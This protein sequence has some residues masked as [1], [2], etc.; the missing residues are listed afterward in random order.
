MIEEILKAGGNRRQH[1]KLP[2]GFWIRKR[3]AGA[4]PVAQWFSSHVLLLG[5]PVQSP[6][7]GMAPL[8]TPYCGRCPTHKVE[9]DGYGC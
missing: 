3:T 7:A 6:G 9:E 2:C 4:G 8:G 5:S 1:S